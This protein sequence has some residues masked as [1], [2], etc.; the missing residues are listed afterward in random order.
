MT[1]VW[2]GSRLPPRAPRTTAPAPT[3]RSSARWPRRSSCAC[4]TTPATRSAIRLPEMDGYV[5]HAFL[6]GIHPGQQYGFR[7]HGP[8]DPAPGP[9]LQPQQAA[10]RPVRQGHRRP[11]RL[12]PVGLRLR[13]RDQGAQRRRLG[14]AHAEVR[15][16]QPVLRLGRRPAAEHAVPQDGHLRGPRQGPDDDQPADARGAARH[17]RRRRAPG[18]D[19]VPAPT[20]ASPRSS[21]MPVHQF[22]QDDT[23]QQK[24]LRNYW[25]YNTIGFFAPHNEY[26]QRHGG[27]AARAGVQGAW[28]AP[29]TR[30]ASR[31]SSTSS[32]TTP[33]RATTSGPTLSFRGIDNRHVLPAGRGRQ[34]VL[35]GLHRH[36]EHPQRPDAAVAAADHGL[37]ALLGH[38][39][40]RRRLPLRPRLD[41]GPRAARRR[42]AV[43]VLRPR[44]TR[45]RSSARSS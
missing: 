14:A 25:G 18:D 45:T 22:V 32:T 5:W 7:V 26:A 40:A 30:R 37:A 34:A 36:R 31:S 39:D 1:Q 21:C 19:R 42:P 17:L 2:P 38:R 41:P 11:D 6:P 35:H 44:A 20:S 24:G 16:H 4:S 3:S 23:L 33:P 8:Y 12:G 27:R 15:R 9:A 29:C 13:L 10:A 43:R 28:S